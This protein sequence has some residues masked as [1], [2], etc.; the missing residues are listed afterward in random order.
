MIERLVIMALVWAASVGGA[1]I[2]GMRV[3]GDRELATQAREERASVAAAKVA[4]DTAAI[5][6][7]NI[8]VKHVQITQPIQR[9]VL[10][11]PVYREC[12]H[13]DEQLRNINEALAPGSVPA[14][15]GL[16]PAVDPAR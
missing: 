13:S 14:G 7:A 3:G 2:Y 12:K 1:F 4:A 11:R 16:L 8:K 15:S 10:D 6:I 5:A 9:E